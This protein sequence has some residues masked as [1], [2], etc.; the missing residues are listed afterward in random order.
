MMP[1]RFIWILTFV[2]TV[3]GFLALVALPLALRFGK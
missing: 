3:L 2:M 1:S